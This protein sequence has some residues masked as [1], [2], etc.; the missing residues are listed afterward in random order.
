MSKTLTFLALSL[1]FSAFNFGDRDIPLKVAHSSS[2]NKDNGTLSSADVRLGSGKIDPIAIGWEQ[3]T[4]Q[5]F[6]FTPMVSASKSY[7]MIGGDNGPAGPS[8]GDT[9][10]YTVTIANAMGAMAATGVQFSDMIDPNTTLIAGTVNSSPIA[11]NDAY[12]TVGNIS[13]SVPAGSGMLSNDVE[14][15]GDI[16]AVDS[17]KTT[18]TQGNVTFNADGSFTFNPAPG[19]E[20]TTTFIYYI[21][22]GTFVR[23]GTVSIT[24]TGIIWFIQAGAPMGGD[25]RLSNPFNN[26]STFSSTAMDEANDNIFIYSGSYGGALTLLPGQKVIG[27]G[28][29]GTNLASLAGVTLS[30]FAPA[31]PA[32]PG[33]NGANPTIAN[34]L[35]TLTL[36]SNNHVLGVTVNNSGGT[37]M[38]GS[39]VGSLKIREVILTN[40]A[41]TAL[42]LASGVL[43]VV[44]KSVSSGSASYGIRISNTTGSLQITGTGTTDGSGG[45]IQNIS[46][47]G[48]E[49]INATNITLQNMMLTS[50][51]TLDSGFDGVCD[52]DDN[53]ACNAAIYLKDVNTV[54]LTN[55]DISTTEEHGINANNV[56]GLTINNCTSTINGNSNEENALKLRNLLGT[57]SITNSSF[58][59]SAFRICHIINNTGNLNLTVSNCTFNNTSSSPVGADCFEMRTQGSATATVNISGSAFQRARSKGI[60]A[61]AEGSST[62]NLNVTDCDIERFGQPMAGIEV[63]SVSTATMNYNI[64][65]NP[66][67]EASQEVA[68]LASTFNSSV[69]NGRL[70]NN[71]N[72]SD[73][74]AS[75]SIF[76]NIRVLHEQSSV[77]K[78][79]IKNNLDINST[80][81]DIPVNGI[82]R[83]GSSSAHRLDIILENNVINC[84]N[85]A[86]LEGVEMRV[87]TL[88]S[89][90]AIN[91]I[92]FY[93]AN[94]T[95]NN[96]SGLRAFRA[97]LIEPTSFMS[98]QGAGPD[99][100]TN[101]ANNG[102][103]NSM[104]TTVVGFAQPPSAIT[105]NASCTPP[106]HA[107]PPPP[108][109]FSEI[110]DASISSLT[111][112]DTVNKMEMNGEVGKSAEIPV[113]EEL[114]LSM[115]GETVSVG[116]MTGFTLP[117]N[118]DITIQFNVRIDDPFPAGICSVSNQGTVT[119]SN[120]SS[121]LTDDPNLGGTSDPTTTLIL[122][123]PAISSCQSDI[124]VGTDPDLCG[125]AVNFA[126][127]ANGCPMPTLS[128]KIGMMSISSGHLFPVGTTVVDVTASNGVAPDATCS[129]MV[130][131][132]DD[133]DPVLSC[134]SGT[135]MRNTDSG[136]CSYQVIGTE[137]DPMVMENCPGYTLTNDFNS[138]SSL[139]GAVL[140]T[141]S[142]MIN[143][144]IT[145]VGG[146]QD[147]CSV[148]VEVSD[149]EAPMITCPPALMTPCDADDL[150][151]YADLTEFESAGGMVS[152]NCDINDGSFT[153]LGQTGT[154]GTFTRTYQIADVNGLTATCMQTITVQD[155]MS[156]MVTKGSIA[157]C[158]LTEQEAEDAAIAATSATD[159]CPGM[160]TY[161]AS[162]AGTCM[163]VITVTVADAA[164]NDASVMYDTRIDG[165]KPM[166]MQG[167]IAPCYATVALAEAAALMATSA[168][169]NC[170]AVLMESVSTVGTCSAT[171]TVTTTDECGNSMS[172]VYMTRIDNEMPMVTTG[173]IDGCYP[174]VAAAEAAAKDATTAT[175][176][177][178]G[179]LIKSAVTMGD[180]SATITVTVTDPCGNSNSTAVYNT[181][182]D[183]TPPM[184]T[185]GMIAAS[186]NSIAEAETAAL[187]ATTATDNCPGI[188]EE[189][190]FTQGECSL[191]ITVTTEDECGNA[192]PVQYFTRIDLA[193]SIAGE[194]TIC[195]GESP[196]VIFESEPTGGTGVI[197]YQWQHSTSGCMGVFTDIP[198]ATSKDYNP[199]ALN[200]TTSYRRIVTSTVGMEACNDTTNCVTITVLQVSAGEISGDQQLCAGEVPDMIS[201]MTAASGTSLS[202]QWQQSED[203]CSGTFVDIPGA[204]GVDY[205]PPALLHSTYF[206]R[207]AFSTVG[208][209]VCSDT[210][211]CVVKTVQAITI[212]TVIQICTAPNVYKLKICFQVEEPGSAEMF[213]I[214]LD[215]LTFG[216]YDYDQ[217]D[218]DGCIEITHPSF[219]PT[220]F[221]T[222]DIV[223]S[224]VDEMCEG[225]YEFTEKV[226]FECP[227]I[228][229]ITSPALICQSGTFDLRATGLSKMAVSENSERD[230]GIRFVAF[231]GGPVMN[232]YLGGINLG[233][234]SFANLSMSN[235]E[236]LLANI[237]GGSLTV[238]GNY[239]IYAVLDQP[240]TLDVTCRPY[241]S[242][243]A[244]LEVTPVIAGAIDGP[245]LV[246]PGLEDLHYSIQPIAN[247][248]SYNWTFSNGSGQIEGGTTASISLD[249]TTGF[250][251]GVLSVTASN[252]CGTSAVKM[253]SLNKAS[254]NLCAF[255]SCLAEQQNL[256]VDNTLL[257]TLGSPDV[258]QAINRL[259]SGATINALRDIVF[260]AGNEILLKP[261]FEVELGATFEAEIKACI[262]SI[263]G[264]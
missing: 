8:P 255:T 17:I 118:K 131:V 235:T 40:T 97:R 213:E 232:P 201:E 18:G 247:A 230:F 205:S 137:F 161:S 188:L 218:M 112:T 44:L 101:W 138:M 186:Y 177:C 187:E 37:A 21:S 150:P 132:T 1:I 182:I 197:T 158:Y 45:T 16:I 241:A 153:Y 79:E 24:V 67:I 215:G 226:C 87:G 144:T 219:D 238:P 133:Q 6:F 70:N 64:N 202:Y 207:I 206:R 56:S 38:L 148:T 51:N 229:G 139:A 209:V 249:L 193:G 244:F 136:N 62:F 63:G 81:L 212:D 157:T 168:M 42:N 154:M 86:G 166:V 96:T 128:Y 129:F 50:A 125:A 48:V 29:V 54:A 264:N 248:N 225:T 47:R 263:Q 120:F 11:V 160:L 217:R 162:T 110:E 119:G 192:T 163:A 159:N 78:V 20:G 195:S 4:G 52:E 151:P 204:Q 65:N 104:G 170:S 108:P 178:D 31:G 236:A 116:G 233:I 43:D 196:E 9:L 208:L 256:I 246:C 234:V 198:G 99:I 73:L 167:T 261:P 200:Q 26:I 243:S 253:L 69:L 28:A 89:G 103:T 165:E 155:M 228:G 258:Y 95:V 164:G 85:A 61:L 124:S 91:T 107:A 237:N 83:F 176:N 152:D 143:W 222:F 102:N 142:T 214:S 252:T 39:S 254:D 59:L 146:L 183:G 184:V 74:P 80:N 114:L 15:D 175:D 242:A 257:N 10:K 171:V 117:E 224:D 240:P 34:A 111:D 76:S 35:T 55:V 245:A 169:D 25:G 98:V 5:D 66:T 216:P 260:R 147:I 100:P 149:N 121:V 71:A 141:G 135:Q 185:Q 172:V 94:N 82:S 227:V 49:V 58:T 53:I 203:G 239:T 223:I 221:E 126:S 194:E 105:F 259:E 115:S 156:P 92:C 19:F 75:A 189:T 30:T 113:V 41:G 220:D 191:I 109:L 60:Q 210:S 2:G 57:C 211:N 68:V 27:Q 106:A 122:I 22:D 23:S 7:I 262:L 179:T 181:R 145:D 32:V 140:P 93:V 36:G 14:L 134:V 199:P 251:G 180:C 174:S 77:A 88:T 123:A 12:N 72:I 250:S 84:T 3:N 46:T 13:I 173:V 130:T 90:T 33:I 190:V 231:A 127:T